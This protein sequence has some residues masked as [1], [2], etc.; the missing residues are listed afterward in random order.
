VASTV[1]IN[2]TEW[3]KGSQKFA[4]SLYH[5]VCLSDRGQCYFPTIPCGTPAP[6]PL[7]TGRVWRMADSSRVQRRLLECPSRRTSSPEP[8]LRADTQEVG[9]IRG[10]R[11]VGL[12]AGY[13][14]DLVREPGLLILLGPD[15]TVVAN[16]T[17][18]ASP[19][20]V[21]RAAQEDQSASGSRRDG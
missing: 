6:L 18:F 20:E 11:Y 16:F 8:A 17:L 15:G 19:D 1:F 14:I 13:W 2:P 4:C 9:P 3:K 10:D 5:E 7:R 21:R 12:P